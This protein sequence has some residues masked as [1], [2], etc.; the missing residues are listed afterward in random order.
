[1]SGNQIGIKIT[2]SHN[3]NYYKNIYN[4]IILKIED[5]ISKYDVESLPDSIV[6]SYNSLET[7]P[8]PAVTKIN[9][10]KI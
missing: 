1:M 7:Y 10:L 4:I 9:N 6:I 5:I 2:E 8:P 3:I